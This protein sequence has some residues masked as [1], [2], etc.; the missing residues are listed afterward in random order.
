[1]SCYG[2]LAACTVKRQR[3]RQ[4]DRD[5]RERERE[6][7]RKKKRKRNRGRE[8]ELSI[9]RLLALAPQTYL[10]HI[11]NI[12]DT[13]LAEIFSLCPH[14]SRRRGCRRR[15]RRVGQE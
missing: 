10:K 9:G 3:Q 11:S 13:L 4:R 2:C 7:E 1:M 12:S 6:R 14:R 8:R 15:R 5:K